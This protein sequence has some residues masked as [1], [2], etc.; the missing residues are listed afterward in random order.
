MNIK[1]KEIDRDF[2]KREH[3]ANFTRKKSLDSLSLV[4]IP[5][6]RLP[7]SVPLSDAAAKEAASIPRLSKPFTPGERDSLTPDFTKRLLKFW[8]FPFPPKAIFGL[9]MSS[10]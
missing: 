4:H 8:S 5:A 6:D 10:W 1:E 2:W 3:D 7:F 9:P